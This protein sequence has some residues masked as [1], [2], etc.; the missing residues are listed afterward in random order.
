M[1]NILDVKQ[2]TISQTILFHL[3]PGIPVIILAVILTNP[4]LGI[5]LPMF[6]SLL[7]IFAFWLIPIQWAIL[8]VIAYKENKRVKNIIEYMTKM[9]AQK[10]ILW[11]IPSIAFAIIVFSFG[12]KFEPTIYPFYD[13]MPKWFLVDRYILPQDNLLIPTIILNFVFRGILL[14]FT[15]EVYFRGFLLPRMNR[16]GKF[17][18]LINAMLFSIYHLFTP[19][20]NISRMLAVLP[21]VCIVYWKRNIHIGIVTHCAVNTLSCLMMFRSLIMT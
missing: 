3:L 8:K 19:W 21:F 13:N 10:I 1:Q 18:P 17:A 15:E 4:Y 12:T 16:F 14:P 6:F 20:E 7:L 9:P 5:G 2:M 11:S